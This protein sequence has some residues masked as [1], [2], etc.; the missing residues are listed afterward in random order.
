[1]EESESAGGP[2]VPTPLVR[3]LPAGAQPGS[4]SKY[5]REILM[6]MA[7]RVEKSPL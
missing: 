2:R 6:F 7:G 4:F 5:Q 1:M 3:I